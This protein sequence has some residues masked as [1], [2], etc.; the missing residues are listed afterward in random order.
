MTGGCVP[1]A[2][3]TSDGTSPS[4]TSVVCRLRRPARTTGDFRSSVNCSDTSCSLGNDRV[5][6]TRSDGFRSSENDRVSLTRPGMATGGGV[7]TVM[8]TG[9]FRSSMKNDGFRS[10][11]SNHVLLTRP[12]M[13]TGGGVPTV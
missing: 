5:L 2:M 8:A 9:D 3:V 10:S 13:T 12:E 4:G 7:P 1:T 11:V 6:L